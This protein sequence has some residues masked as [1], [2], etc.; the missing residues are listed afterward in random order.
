M[1][2]APRNMQAGQIVAL[3]PNRGNQLITSSISMV[4]DI[5]LEAHIH[6]NSFKMTDTPNGSALCFTFDALHI[7]LITIYYFGVEVLNKSED[8]TS[9]F[10]VET[11]KFPAPCSYKFPKGLDQS[12]PNEVSLINLS[13]FESELKSNEM[14]NRFPIIVTIKAEK[15]DF[16]PYESSFLRVEKE[17]NSWKPVLLKQKIHFES[18]T[19]ALE[20]IYGLSVMNLDANECIV[21]FSGPSTVTMIPC[22]HLCLCEDCAKILSDSS[23]KKCPMCRT[24]NFYLAVN[25]LL[26]ISR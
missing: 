21:C 13:L 22:K 18:T 14:Q 5:E 17:K 19:Y 11:N 10:A 8:H 4:P 12:F 26:F 16:Y 2:N 25:E 6:K 24:S 15:S 23:I 9:Y 3:R 7:C 20:E 1:G